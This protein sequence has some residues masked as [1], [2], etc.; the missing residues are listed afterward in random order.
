M[1]ACLMLTHNSSFHVA[2]LT[3]LQDGFFLSVSMCYVHL[4]TH[5]EWIIYQVLI[6]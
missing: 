4:A 3:I 6:M 1:A 2:Y 5:F